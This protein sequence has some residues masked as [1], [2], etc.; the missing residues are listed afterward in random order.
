MKMLKRTQ[1]M[2][3]SVGILK[4]SPIRKKPK[5]TEQIQEQKVDTA[6]M[7]GLFIEIWDEIPHRSEVSGTWLGDEPK[8]WM[9]DHL[10][11]KSKWPELMH[12]KENIALVT[13]DEHT[14][15]T[16]G[17]ADEKHKELIKQAKQKFN[18]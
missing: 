3:R 8:S 18:V 2:K 6:R 4:R 12:E 16:N 11:E 17:F 13:F 1:P 10:L 5:T 9:F 14:R 7:W 15:K